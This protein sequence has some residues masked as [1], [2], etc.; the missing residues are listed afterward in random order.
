MVSKIAVADMV[1]GA[2]CGCFCGSE[3]SFEFSIL[4][5]MS[6]SDVFGGWSA[7]EFSILHL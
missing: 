7:F 4:C 5:L 6:V 3:S 1:D 2:D